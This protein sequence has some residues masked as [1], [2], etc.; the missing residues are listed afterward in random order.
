M[1]S[2]ASE[3]TRTDRD[4]EGSVVRVKSFDSKTNRCAWLAVFGKTMTSSC[5]RGISFSLIR[6]Y[7]SLPLR[8][9]V[10]SEFPWDIRTN[11]LVRALIL[12]MVTFVTCMQS[13]REAKANLKLVIN[14]CQSYVIWCSI[15]VFHMVLRALA[16]YMYMDS[17]AS[18]TIETEGQNDHVMQLVN[19]MVMKCPTVSIVK[20]CYWIH[21]QSGFVSDVVS[22]LKHL[23]WSHGYQI[24]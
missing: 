19:S 20:S 13:T 5:G 2:A 6:Y 7:D 23:V 12:S 4:T 24:P 15:L 1:P 3:T 11:Y 10:I 8:H 14:C 16:L 21:L 9:P 18:F 22:Q 17:I